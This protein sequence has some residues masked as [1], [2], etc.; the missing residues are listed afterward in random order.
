MG[1]P[2]KDDVVLGD[3]F[4]GVPGVPAVNDYGY[5]GVEG[6]KLELNAKFGVMGVSSEG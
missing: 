1:P 4:L 2:F 5:G 3:L 6:G